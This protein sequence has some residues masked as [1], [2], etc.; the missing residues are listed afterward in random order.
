MPHKID[1]CVLVRT[2]GGV[3]RSLAFAICNNLDNQG[4]L[5]DDGSV[6]DRRDRIQFKGGE[7]A[8]EQNL[9]MQSSID[10]SKLSETNKTVPVMISR[11]GVGQVVGAKVNWSKEALEQLQ[12]FMETDDASRKVYL[13]H[14]SLKKM[15]QN[16]EPHRD[17]NDWIATLQA[18]FRIEEVEF[19]GEKVLGLFD[20]MLIHGDNDKSNMLL[21]RTKESP[22]QLFGSLHFAALVEP[23]NVDGEIIE[24]IQEIKSVFSWDIVPNADFGKMFN[25]EETQA[26]INEYAQSINK[27]IEE[28]KNMDFKKYGE[29]HPK[30]AEKAK[31]EMTQSTLDEFK[32]SDEYTEIVKGNDEKD[33]KIA[34]LSATKKEGDG[35]TEPN[36]E[37]VEIIA[38]NKVLNEENKK[39]TKQLL[40]IQLASNVNLAS[41]IIGGVL[42]G[43]E[44][45]EKVKQ[46]IISQ[47]SPKIDK[48][49]DDDGDL[50]Q[51]EYI[52]AV[53]TEVD[54]WADVSKEIVQTVGITDPKNNSLGED[55][56]FPDEFKDDKF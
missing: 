48:Y 43:T 20:D 6:I 56:L 41:S 9:I 24:D 7:F 45:P 13:G 12:T 10:F 49:L 55:G 52:A 11:T 33:K 30:E 17:M 47:Y 51:D 4:R 1:Q 23:I 42:A 3:E 50:K 8:M 46:K 27:H 35:K 37:M 14:K 54:D 53:Q 44:L 2:N 31:K 36:A 22:E 16:D 40:K 25:P 5:S 32:K 28:V 34:E 19:K 29:L 39:T 38:Q 21:N 15:A 26:C 18:N